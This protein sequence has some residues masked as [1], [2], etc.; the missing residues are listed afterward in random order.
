[1]RCGT[2]SMRRLLFQAFI[3]LTAI[4]C[5]HIFTACIVICMMPSV[6]F[7][8]YAPV[9]LLGMVYMIPVLVLGGLNILL[10][11]RQRF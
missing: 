6:S 2:V 4:M 8:W 11:L 10:W 5:I 3:L 1:M 9:Y 7:P